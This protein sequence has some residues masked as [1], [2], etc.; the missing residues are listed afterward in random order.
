MLFGLR[1]CFVPV[2]VLLIVLTVVGELSWWGLPIALLAL[3]WGPV[4]MW[5]FGGWVNDLAE[6]RYPDD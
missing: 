2:A 6:R 4:A 1:V 3:W 5:H